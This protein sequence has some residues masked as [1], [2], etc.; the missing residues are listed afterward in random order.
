MEP[1]RDEMDEAFLEQVAKERDDLLHQMEVLERQIEE[2]CARDDFEKAELLDVE[3][4][5][6]R[7][8]LD[9]VS[10]M[11]PALEEEEQEEDVEQPRQGEINLM[12]PAVVD[13]KAAPTKRNSGLGAPLARGS[14]RFSAQKRDSGVWQDIPLTPTPLPHKARGAPPS[15]K[16]TPP[17]LAPEVLPEVMMTEEAVV[18]A[19]VNP[20]IQLALTDRAV[21]DRIFSFLSP[22]QLGRICRVSRVW[23]E[24]IEQDELW[25]PVFRPEWQHEVNPSPGTYKRWYGAMRSAALSWMSPILQQECVKHDSFAGR[26]EIKSLGSE[27]FLVA[28]GTAS[29][30]VWNYSSLQMLHEIKAPCAFALGAG[31]E[32][33]GLL[34]LVGGDKKAGTW[35]VWEVS[36]GKKIFSCQADEGAF[37]GGWFIVFREHLVVYR[38]LQQSLRGY[39]WNYDSPILADITPPMHAWEIQGNFTMPKATRFGLLMTDYARGLVRVSFQDGALT[40]LLKERAEDLDA[41]NPRVKFTIDRGGL[42]ISRRSLAKNA[43]V[44]MYDH[45]AHGLRL[46]TSISVVSD[47]KFCS[48]SEDLSVSFGVVEDGDGRPLSGFVWPSA[49]PRAAKLLGLKCANS[50]ARYLDSSVCNNV[51]AGLFGDLLNPSELHLWDVTTGKELSV[52]S[53]EIGQRPYQILRFSGLTACLVHKDGA[54]TKIRVVGRR[55]TQDDPSGCALQ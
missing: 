43:P 27:A 48:V 35:T 1:R 6:L 42:Q 52:L 36:T 46:A 50:N 18:I 37:S 9:L 33:D 25:Q 2:L 14:A 5:T 41:R 29:A 40:V 13:V 23:R 26:V 47:A 16:P 15:H 17:R 22:E 10:A 30:T 8:R 3:L 39:R 19:P 53:S 11:V 54:L 21:L 20:A 38:R 34:R 4:Q 7:H 45:T 24:R 32:D 44:L 31:L 12:N 55:K 49:T 51:V 28:M